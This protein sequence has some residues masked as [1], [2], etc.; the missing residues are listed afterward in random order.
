MDIN[1]VNIIG[2]LTRDI[3]LK[4]TAGGTTVGKASIAINR[5]V[6]RS[7]EWTEEGNFFDVVMFG[8]TAENIA[9]YAGKGKQIG[10]SG[11]LEQQRW[12]KDG[13]QRSKIVIIANSVQLLGVKSDGG[14]NSGGFNDDDIPFG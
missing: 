8:K 3:E 5:R 9:K 4:S 6:K 1:S 12:E 13:Q 7:G 11:E 10:I 14:G 2:R